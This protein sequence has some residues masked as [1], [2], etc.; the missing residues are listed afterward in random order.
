MDKNGIFIGIDP[1][2]ILFGIQCWCSFP[3]CDTSQLGSQRQQKEP[4]GT[5]WVGIWICSSV[6]WSK[7]KKS[8]RCLRLHS[9]F[10]CHF[11]LDIWMISG[12]YLNMCL[13]ESFRL[14][15]TNS[16]GIFGRLVLLFVDTMEPNNW[17]KKWDRWRSHFFKGRWPKVRHSQATRVR[18]T[19]ANMR[20]ILN[21]FSFWQ[22]ERVAPK[23][24]RE[25]QVKT[26]GPPTWRVSVQ[27]WR[28]SHI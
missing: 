26:I 16:W 25:Y 20:R 8:A 18:W 23:I 15:Y 9:R 11:C 5:E 2:T 14:L 6:S 7:T 4:P 22:C 24:F 19:T 13:L 3:T 12:W 27:L 28:H 17:R 21:V 10:W 1:N